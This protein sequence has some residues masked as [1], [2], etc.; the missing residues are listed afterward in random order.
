MA[1]SGSDIAV[2]VVDLASSVSAPTAVADYDEI[3]GMDTIAFNEERISLDKTDFKDAAGARA[4]FM[5]LMSGSVTLSGFYVAGDTGQGHIRAA[6]DGDKDQVVWV[7]VAWTGDP[8]DGTDHVP[9]VV[10][11]INRSTDVAGRVEISYSLTFSGK[12]VAGP[13]S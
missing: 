4:Y 3:C 8:A 12:S 2:Y 11:S 5:G 10:E 13:T 1:L 7:M 6:K 9:C